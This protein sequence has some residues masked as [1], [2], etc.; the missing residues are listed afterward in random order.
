MPPWPEGFRSIAPLL[1]GR[2]IALPETRESEVLAALIERRG[3][4]VLHCPLVSILDAPDAPVIEDWL[5][6]FIAQPP[7]LLVVFTGEG[8]RRLC[9]F[10]ERAGLLDDFITAMRKTTILARGPKPGRALREYGVAVDLQ[11]E[12]PTTQGVVATLAT[13]ELEGKGVA[14]QLYGE[15]PNPPLRA[16]LEEQGARV[17]VVAPYRYAPKS[18]DR[19]VLALI[20]TLAAGQ[21]DAMVFTSKA[22][23]QRLFAVAHDHGVT[24]SLVLAL[25]SLLVA[26]VGPVVADELERHGVAAGAIPASRWFMKPLV[27]TLCEHLGGPLGQDA[28]RAL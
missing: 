4:Q 28:I 12:R 16:A 19:Q 23:V 25:G 13:L 1:S 27:S 18:Q 9:G 5:Q 10:A 20:E 2:V 7:A 24:K 8:V 14:V 15:E 26:A 22:Q 3:G 6:D 21:V 17:S 11:A